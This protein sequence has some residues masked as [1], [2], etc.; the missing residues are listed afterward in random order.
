[1]PSATDSRHRGDEAAIRNLIVAA[2]EAWNRGDAHAYSEHF[3]HDGGFTNILG[4]TLYGRDSFESRH[5][6]IFLTMFRGSRLKQTIRRIRFIHPEV[7]I[8]DV[9]AEVSGYQSLPRGV[10][11]GADGILRTQLQQV[12]LKKRGEWW[13]VAYH[14]TDVKPVRGE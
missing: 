4:I 1:M 14:N 11:S 8:A 7:A 10:Q 12:F 3:D 9:D 2:T 5:A 6:E 13:M